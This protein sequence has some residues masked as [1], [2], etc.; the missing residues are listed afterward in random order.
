VASAIP[1]TIPAAVAATIATAMPSALAAA[2]TAALATAMSATVTQAAAMALP[3]ALALSSADGRMSMLSVRLAAS[4]RGHGGF[5][6]CLA[7]A[8]SMRGGLSEVGVSSLSVTETQDP[9]V[10][11]KG[12]GN[13]S[14]P[15]VFPAHG[16]NIIRR[17]AGS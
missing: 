14:P 17:Y 2:V 12:M 7:F 13:L 1:A 16:R 3:T 6:V 9:G 4:C 10:K 8:L 15:H 11:P 5:S